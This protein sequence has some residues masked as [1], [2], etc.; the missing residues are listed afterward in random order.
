M[1][2]YDYKPVTNLPMHRS[3]VIEWNRPSFDG[4]Y[5]VDQWRVTVNLTDGKSRLSVTEHLHKTSQERWW[6]CT[7]S[8]QGWSW[9]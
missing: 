6:M 1:H 3:I 7:T 8:R 5:P 9:G 2:I 4:N